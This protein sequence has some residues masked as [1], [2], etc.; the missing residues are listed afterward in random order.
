MNLYS[1]VLERVDISSFSFLVLQVRTDNPPCWVYPSFP[2][3]QFNKQHNTTQPLTS[4]LGQL[5][6]GKL[7]SQTQ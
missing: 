2:L 1:G 3:E 7:A 4:L 6:R 5:E